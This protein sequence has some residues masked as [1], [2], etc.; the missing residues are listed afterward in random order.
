M[1]RGEIWEVDLPPPP[2]GIGREQSGTRPAL[3]LQATSE[4]DNPMCVIAPFTSNPRA[5]RFPYTH[6]V[7]PSRSNGLTEESVIM[8][9]QLRALDKKRLLHRLGIM[10]DSTMAS[11]E[12]S[13][14]KLLGFA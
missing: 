10:T 8:V 11:V 3:I 2:G 4:P 6:L 1:R 13:L 5:T 14:R 12:A 9:F 7:P